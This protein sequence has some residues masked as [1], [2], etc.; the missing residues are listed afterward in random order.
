MLLSGLLF[1][2]LQVCFSQDSSSQ[3]AQ[4]GFLDMS[5]SNILR[6]VELAIRAVYF[7]ARE[8]LECVLL[9]ESS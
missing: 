2:T 8:S 9:L 6:Q 3:A 5:T 1:Q 7:G 4:F